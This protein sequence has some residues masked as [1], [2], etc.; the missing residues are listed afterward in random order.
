MRTVDYAHVT[1]IQPHLFTAEALLTILTNDDT[2]WI[3]A[4]VD[5][6]Q[7]R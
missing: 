7:N 1:E 4:G 5:P 6:D 3:L 2:P